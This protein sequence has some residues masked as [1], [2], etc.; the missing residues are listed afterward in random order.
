MD[1]I[2]SSS[3]NN[4]ACLFVCLFFVASLKVAPVSLIPDFVD[5]S[6]PRVLFNNNLVGCFQLLE[7]YNNGRDV[8]AQG[9][10]DSNV[11]SFC[12][13]LGWNEELDHLHKEI[14]GDSSSST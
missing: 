10:C 6:C 14:H 13:M 2:I 4:T 1:I 3:Y 12:E 11:K 7:E 8:W 9:D 5:Q